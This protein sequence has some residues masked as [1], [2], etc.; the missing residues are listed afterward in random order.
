MKQPMQTEVEIGGQSITITVTPKI[1]R[2][3]TSYTAANNY[4]EP[5]ADSSYA[6]ANAA[7]AAEVEELEHILKEPIC[8]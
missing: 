8:L 6:S 7:L 2:F 4:A 1:N 5:R 3:G